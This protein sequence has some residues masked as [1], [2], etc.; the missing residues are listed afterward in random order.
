MAE[1]AMAQGAWVFISHSHRDLDKVRRVRNAL[2]ERGHNPLLFF[3]KCLGDHSEIDSLIRREIEARTH[4]IL[5]DSPNAKASRWVQAEAEIIK[6]LQERE[7]EVINLDDAWEVQLQGIQKVAKR[8]TVAV[9]YAW[10][11][12]AVAEAI[13]RRL[14]DQDYAVFLD[15]LSLSPGEAWDA[16]RNRPLQDALQRGW[17]FVL[18]SPD[19]VQSEMVTKKEVFAFLEM[20]DRYTNMIPVLV[21]DRELTL[22][23]LRSWPLGV[24]W[25]PG[26]TFERIQMVDL[27]EHDLDEG[28]SRLIRSLKTRDAG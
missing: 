23:E 13:A 7:C 11:D 22:H 17:V 5:C 25:P 15:K 27:T 2:E 16:Q 18:L 26:Y 6:G 20:S 4:F 1:E 10:A 24:C 9:S 19:L 3:L 28:I 8:A 12:S 14:R 21:R